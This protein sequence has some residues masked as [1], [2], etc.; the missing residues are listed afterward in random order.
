MKNPIRKALTSP[1]DGDLKIRAGLIARLTKAAEKA[2]IILLHQVA[3][4]LELSNDMGEA[5]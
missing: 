5:K 2:P 3:M 1:M 4:M